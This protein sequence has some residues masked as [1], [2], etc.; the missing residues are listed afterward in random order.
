M[1]KE[2]AV[3]I[4]EKE[5]EKFRALSYE[6]IASKIGKQENFEY[7]TEKGEPYRVEVDVFYDDSEDQ[8]IRVISM[9]SYSFWT[10]ISPVSSGFIVAPD[11]R[12]VGE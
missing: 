12:F 7:S 3:E 2:E 6:E 9:I 4:A 11:G 8:N 10:D 5:L 1:N